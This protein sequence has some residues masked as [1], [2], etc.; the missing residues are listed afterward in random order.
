VILALAAGCGRDDIQVY[1]VS[2]EPVADAGAAQ[3]AGLPPNHPDVS[4]AGTPRLQWKLPEGW[5][6]VPPGEMR[7]ASFKVID[8]ANKQADVSVVPLPGRA[9]GDLANVNRWRD[10]VGLGPVEQDQLAKLAELV[11]VAGE[12]AQLFDQAGTNA[13][14]GEPTRILAAVLNREG[15]AWFFK[16]TG[17]DNLVAKQKS[18]FVGFLNSV[19]FPAA[20]AQ[21]QSPA[22]HPPLDGGATPSLLSGT[23][24]SAEGRPAWDV[25]AGWREMPAGQFLVAK[26]GLSGTGSAQTTVNVSRSVGD[27]G[28]ALANVNRWR[29]QLGLTPLAASDLAALLR[30]VPVADGKAM[31]VEM[32]GA[33]RNGQKS[34]LVAAIVSQG[35][36]TWFYKLMGD[37]QVVEREKEAFNKF[38]Q[39]VKY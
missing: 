3:A 20:R 11:E 36:Q 6:E 39:G 12:S 24:P 19:T 29:T 25:P 28:G 5:Q 31:F 7:V 22:S 9:G 33:E 13:A 23:A 34:Q 26:F 10:Q 14:S 1:K 37:A 21:A 18:A 35:G 2:K 4:Q 8:S 15:T 32:T 16:M 38:V 27:G 17:D 30:E